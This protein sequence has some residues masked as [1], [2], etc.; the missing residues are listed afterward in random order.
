M[1]LSEAE[2]LELLRLRKRR[3][4]AAAPQ[5]QGA[6]ATIPRGFN[7]GLANVLG[8]PV[9][10][11]NMALSGVD[12][13]AGTQLSGDQPVMG[14][15]FLR[16]AL[17][18][19][20]R[21]PALQ[22][23]T[24]DSLE[25][26]NPS[27][28]KFAVAGETLGGS[29]LPAA[30][31]YLMARGAISTPRVMQPVVDA[32]RR[33]PGAFGATEAGLAAGSAQGAMIAE[34]VAPGSEGARFAGEVAGGVLNPTAVV[35]GAVN[36][37]SGPVR[38]V[39]NAFSPAGR[40][41]AAAD[42]VQGVL[43]ESGEDTDAVI[44]ALR[45]SDPFKLDLTSGQRTGSQGLL[46]I[47][48]RL[49]ADSPQ[50][51]ASMEAK[52]GE[53]FN[54]LRANAEAVAAS[55]QPQALVAG[56]QER[57][58]QTVG[59]AR[60]RERM[61]REA[62][63]RAR[64]PISDVNRP[65]MAQAGVQA[66]EALEAAKQSAKG[67]ERA[68]WEAVPRD[69]AIEPENVIQARET[70]RARLLPNEALPQP[71][72]TFTRGLARDAD[73]TVD[74]G[75]L[76]AAGRPITREG[77][78]E[79]T[80]GELLRLRSR[81]LTMARD[82]RARGDFDLAN[83]MNL[84][85][86]GALDDLGNISDS[87]RSYTRELSQRFRQGFAGDVLARDA[88]GG[89]RIEP[90]QTLERAFGTGGTPADVRMRQLTEAADFGGQGAAMLTQQDQFLRGAARNMINESTGRVDPN[91]LA[92]FQR[93]NAALLERFPSLKRDLANAESA[94][95]AF[96]RVEAIA[97][98]AVDRAN[99]SLLAQFVGPNVNPTAV[100]G[101]ILN[102]ARGDRV[103]RFESLAR[104]VQKAGP[105]AVAGLRSAAL[106]NVFKQAT[107][108]TGA[109]NFE[110]LAQ[111]LLY[112]GPSG[113]DP[114]LLEIMR[115]NNVLDQA[116]DKRLRDIVSRAAR[117]QT[118]LDTP[119]G[120][121]KLVPEADALSNFITRVIGARIGAQAGSG[122]G[123]T[124]VAASAGSKLLRNFM[125][126]IPANKTQ[127]ILIEAANNP[128]FM[129]MLLEKP[130]TAKQARDLTRQMNAYLVNAGIVAAQPEE[131]RPLEQSM[132]AYGR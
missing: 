102:P 74:T 7:T 63:E 132:N 104:S 32:V 91:R 41:R 12:R 29:M 111:S 9:D 1:A 110:R 86:E 119:A 50:F 18:G 120:M 65:Q 78:A 93:E 92:R 17:R 22:N 13:I 10:V 55:G 71:V 97:E 68:A 75:V 36:L 6:L 4:E 2:E 43:R 66:R 127:D 95:R 19:F 44:N 121:D 123:A 116:A 122:S 40:E 59:L 20:D 62:A 100:I 72:E 34:H 45:A 57:V 35:R 39:Y 103:Q 14:S 87:A 52:P 94:E 54:F 108:Q 69:I 82:A 85:A 107:D 60:T 118:A 99:R 47:E 106:E 33:S 51:A 5:A 109:F 42:I 125:E 11:A 128:R 84:I 70:I 98:R 114:S 25:D 16:K 56:A 81:A 58:G 67:T 115:R 76:D 96:G 129:A 37:G 83:Q 46:A 28:R 24:Y 90:E 8:F 77:A 126:R 48:R 79:A 26:L 80:S 105:E 61:A 130:T 73:Q 117:L 49:A 30:A 64:A 112:K 113:R 3:A 88:T 21:V 31:P 53:A 27:D 131:E 15:R 101:D 89:P 124:L 38:Q 23:V